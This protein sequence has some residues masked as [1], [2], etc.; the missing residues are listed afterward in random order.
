MNQGQRNRLQ[1]VINQLDRLWHQEFAPDSFELFQTISGVADENKQSYDNLTNDGLK[2]T[3]NGK[4]MHEANCSLPPI[5]TAI[6]DIMKDLAPSY[7]TPIKLSLKQK[8]QIK[9]IMKE[10]EFFAYKN[11]DIV[12]C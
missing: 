11:N 12:S 10:L 4:W 7:Q 9:S 2:S 3:Q 8:E 6:Q 5:A 1:V